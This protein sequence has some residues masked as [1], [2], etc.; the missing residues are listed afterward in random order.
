[1]PYFGVFFGPNTSKSE[2]SAKIRLPF[3]RCKNSVTL[4]KKIIRKLINDPYEKYWTV[5]N[6]QTTL[7]S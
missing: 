5:G 3:P 4:L 7:I 6:E 1:M 2:I